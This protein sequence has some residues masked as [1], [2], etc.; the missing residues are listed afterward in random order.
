M[1]SFGLVGMSG[2]GIIISL[3][4]LSA[5]VLNLNYLLSATVAIERLIRDI[6]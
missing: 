6:A 4:W 3:M 2:A 1:I 5:S